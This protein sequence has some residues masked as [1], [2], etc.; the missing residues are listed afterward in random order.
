VE[1]VGEGAGGCEVGGG[2]AGGGAA[3]GTRGECLGRVKM[4]GRGGT[5]KTQTVGR[6]CGVEVE[7]PVACVVPFVVAIVLILYGVVDQ[8]VLRM[9]RWTLKYDGDQRWYEEK[10][11]IHSMYTCLHM[12]RR[13]CEGSVIMG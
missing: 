12:Q 10:T 9:Q 4:G 3:A 5:Y 1:D 13:R 7:G 11:N 2:G 6:L 8:G